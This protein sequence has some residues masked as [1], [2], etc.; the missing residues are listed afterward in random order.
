MTGIEA[1][2]TA[3]IVPPDRAPAYLRGIGIAV[4]DL[5]AA[6]R[7]GERAAAGV[8]AFAPVMAA[9]LLRWVEVVSTLRRRLVD[10]GEWTLGDRRGQPIC[11]HLT[12]GRTLAV[13]SG[14]VATGN[15]EL[16][17]GPHTVRRKGAATADSFAPHEMLF[18]LAELGSSPGP[19]VR[20]PAPG[21]SSTAAT[22]RGRTWRSRSPPA[23]IGTRGS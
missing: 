3:L 13:M 11:R 20:R 15:P 19:T 8:D 7:A 10:T 6:V 23:S 17:G 4:E 1:L 5:Y 22:A 18:S 12:S 14:D 21:S 9:G 16:P 2:P